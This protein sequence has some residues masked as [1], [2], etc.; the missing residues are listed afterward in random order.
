[1]SALINQS[2]PK[3]AARETVLYLRKDGLQS[4]DELFR[5]A[6]AIL[7]SKKSGPA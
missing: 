3:K 2:V 4:F 5:N 7:R 6:T 1:M